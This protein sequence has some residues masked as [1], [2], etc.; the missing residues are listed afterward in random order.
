MEKPRHL[1]ALPATLAQ[2]AAL[3]L[4]ES[5]LS[6]KCQLTLEMAERWADRSLALGGGVLLDIPERPG[7]PDRP[8]LVPPHKVPRRSLRS[9]QGM[10]AMLHAI[11]HIELNAID[12]ALDIIAR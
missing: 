4:G 9:Q 5:D 10:V 2:A 3:A 12:L 11:A 7:R 8:E 1:E 6:R